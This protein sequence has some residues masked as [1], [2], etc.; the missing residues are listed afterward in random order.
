MRNLLIVTAV[1]LLL[2]IGNIGEAFETKTV[3]VTLAAYNLK[4]ITTSGTRTSNS[5][6]AFH[7]DFIKEHRVKWGDLAYIPGIGMRSIE[8]KMKRIPINRHRC[9]VWYPL[10][11]QECRVIGIRR[12]QITLI[13]FRIPL[14]KRLLKLPMY[15]G[16]VI[17][18]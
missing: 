15:A 5:T 14:I 3:T 6:I 2:M 12:A 18:K 17:G 13:T 10:N 8:D 7:P 1:A 16:C 4:G 11:Y 9:D